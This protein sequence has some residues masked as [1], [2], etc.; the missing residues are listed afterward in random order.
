VARM[1]VV[2]CGPAGAGKTTAARQSGLTVYDRDDPEWTS[3]KQFTTR[4]ADLARDPDAQAVVIRSGATSSAR[5]KAAALVGATHVFL[6]LETP[7][8]LARRVRER[9]RADKVAGL[10]S[11]KGWFDHFD[12]NDNT[13]D[14]PSWSAVMASAEPIGT[15]E[16]W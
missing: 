4:L 8:E 16:V 3:E 10:T 12:R 6:L 14:F 5:A 9:G 11:I 15:S 13:P 7:T 2:L 1:V